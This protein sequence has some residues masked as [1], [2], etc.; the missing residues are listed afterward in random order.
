MP[1]VDLMTSCSLINV[2]IR[3]GS[4]DISNSGDY[5]RLGKVIM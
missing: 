2:L 5:V 1:Q 3:R 4:I